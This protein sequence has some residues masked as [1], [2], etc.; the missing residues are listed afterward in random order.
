MNLAYTP[1]FHDRLR[2]RILAEIESQIQALAQGSAEDFADYKNR[3]GLIQG[4]YR[5]VDLAE[6]VRKQLLN[7]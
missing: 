2:T 7:D 6:E 1:V 5:C 4:L 3:V